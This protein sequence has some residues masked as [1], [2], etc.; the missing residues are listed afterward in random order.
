MHKAQTKKHAPDYVLIFIIFFLLL[1]GLIMLASASVVVGQD[2]FADKYYFLKHQFFYG[3][4]P[5]LAA[6]ILCSKINHQ[7]WEKIS[8]PF[9]VLVII[10]LGLVFFPQVSY[11]HAGARRW[12]NI[13]GVSLQPSEF[14]KLAFVVYLAAWLSKRQ[15]KLK[16]FTHGF[17][18]YLAW[19]GIIM[20]LLVLQP[21]MGTLFI[22]TVISLVVYFVAGGKLTH[23][24]GLIFLGGSLFA[25]LIKLAPYRLARITAYLNPEADPLGI[26]YQIQQ[27]ILALGSGGLFGL[28]LGH[29]RQKFAYLPEVTGD[30][31][32]AVIGE[33]LGFVFA[34]IL[35]LT[36]IILIYQGFKIARNSS[37]TYSQLL[38]VGITTWFGFQALVNIG[39]MVRVLPLTGLPLPFI[40]YGSSA[41]LV[42]MAASGILI[43][44]SRFTKE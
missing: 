7:F 4:I 1:F 43:N 34:F 40:S 5:G 6:L 30:S 25:L 3:F 36:F 13:A 33:E 8:L 9:L 11:L 23:L 14:L 41:L 42:S 15:E 37:K 44:V 35:I 29:S 2:N 28:G 32:F 16:D 24:A 39:A 26:S 17:L 31:I 22:V 27:A 21:D 12:L 10:F 18:P 20:L 19:L 38:V